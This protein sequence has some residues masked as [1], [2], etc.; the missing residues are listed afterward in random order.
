MRRSL[1]RGAEMNVGVE[2]D[3]VIVEAGGAIVSAGR[4]VAVGLEIIGVATIGIRVGLGA[5]NGGNPQRDRKNTNEKILIR[6][7]FM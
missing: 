6:C 1:G 7:V 4:R 2:G 5:E 3:G